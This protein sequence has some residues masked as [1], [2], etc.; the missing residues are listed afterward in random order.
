MVK[1][2]AVDA[3]IVL[4]DLPPVLTR[5]SL[6]SSCG[7]DVTAVLDIRAFQSAVGLVGIQHRRPPLCRLHIATTPTRQR[8]IGAGDVMGPPAL[9]HHSAGRRISQSGCR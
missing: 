1:G 3:A 9:E 4:F 8:R 6:Y 7:D 2:C 5:A